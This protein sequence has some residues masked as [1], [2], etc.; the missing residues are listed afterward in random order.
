MKEPFFE[1]NPFHYK[2]LTPYMNESPRE[3]LKKT[4]FCPLF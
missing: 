3:T 4:L 1:K 2:D